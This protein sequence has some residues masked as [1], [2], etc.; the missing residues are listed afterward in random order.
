[1][2]TKR[3]QTAHFSRKHRAFHEEL[4]AVAIS[5]EAGLTRFEIPLFVEV[6]NGMNLVINAEEL[7]FE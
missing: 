2:E 4:I 3:A 1:M 5:R 7:Q 6:R